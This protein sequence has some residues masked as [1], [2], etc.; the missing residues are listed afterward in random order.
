MRQALENPFYYLDNFQQ[1]LAWVDQHHG[2]LL[3]D[4]ELAPVAA[5]QLKHTL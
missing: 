1:V 4:A 5:A 2:D 3:D